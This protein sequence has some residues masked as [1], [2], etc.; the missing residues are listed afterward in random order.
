ML[1]N[2]IDEIID[3]FDGLQY[4]GLAKTYKGKNYIETKPILWEDNKGNYF[5]VVNKQINFKKNPTKCGISPVYEFD[6]Y[7]Y[8]QCLNDDKIAYYLMD[9]MPQSIT[10]GTISLPEVSKGTAAIVKCIYEDY[11]GCNDVNLCVNCC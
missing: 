11:T 10:F 1:Q 5:Y 4:L 9:K 8:T 7:I 3:N 2:A 6:L